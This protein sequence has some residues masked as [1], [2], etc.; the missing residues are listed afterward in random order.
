MYVYGGENSTKMLTELWVFDPTVAMWT[1]LA[2]SLGP[3]ATSPPSA[4]VYACATS[5]DG[6]VMA[7]FGGLDGSSVPVSDVV[8]EL[9]GL[10]ATQ[11]APSWQ[12]PSDFTGTPPPGRGHCALLPRSSGFSV[13]GGVATGTNPI[14][15]YVTQYSQS[16]NWSSGVTE[17]GLTARYGHA[18]TG[19]H[20]DASVLVYGGVGGSGMFLTTDGVLIGTP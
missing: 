17:T 5:V 11:P 16:G 13:F 19:V 18:A 2:P 10:V 6:T 15:D 20:S 4:R 3:S 7:I 12:V 9:S 1:Q 14:D 8:W